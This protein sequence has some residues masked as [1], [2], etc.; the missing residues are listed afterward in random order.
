MHIQTYYTCIYNYAYMY[1]GLCM[2]YSIIE[3][4]SGPLNAVIDSKLLWELCLGLAV[5]A[6]H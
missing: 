4:I 1:V 3:L 5:G 6:D 2:H